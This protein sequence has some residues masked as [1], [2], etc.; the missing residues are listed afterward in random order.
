VLLGGNQ[1]VAVGP[2][3]S[4]EEDE[5]PVV[6]VDDVLKEPDLP[7]TILQTKQGSVWKLWCMASMSGW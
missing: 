7:F 3:I 2:G 4:V 1:G 6:L 5:R